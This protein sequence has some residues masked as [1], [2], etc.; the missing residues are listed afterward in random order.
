MSL[1][2]KKNISPFLF[3]SFHYLRFLFLALFG[4]VLFLPPA[5][6]RFSS[7]PSNYPLAEP[8]CLPREKLVWN[9]FSSRWRFGIG[10]GAEMGGWRR[11][12][13][14][15][16]LLSYS[17]S[18]K[19]LLCYLCVLWA[20]LVWCYLFYFLLIWIWRMTQSIWIIRPSSSPPRNRRDPPLYFPS[21]FVF[22]LSMHSPLYSQKLNI[23]SVLLNI[24]KLQKVQISITLCVFA[25]LLPLFNRDKRCFTFWGNLSSSAPNKLSHLHLQ[26]RQA[27]TP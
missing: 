11:R 17:F 2:Y 14:E 10:A 25:N 16:G 15:I 5:L 26:I 12:K 4:F 21:L 22:I 3:S 1:T 8:V 7:N 24:H 27:L 9:K 19:W 20:V 18:C 13:R 6:E 23:I